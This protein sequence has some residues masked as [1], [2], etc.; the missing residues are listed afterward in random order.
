MI[1]YACDCVG[2]L[3]CCLSFGFGFG[4]CF[5]RLVYAGFS[6]LMVWVGCDC[7]LA[8]VWFYCFCG[9]VADWLRVWCYFGLGWVWVLD[10][11]GLRCGFMVVWRYFGLV[12]CV[13]DSVWVVICLEL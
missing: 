10:F 6:F 1:V 8:G 12:A 5:G 9:F 7:L 2:C 3:V 13:F 11:F 4:V